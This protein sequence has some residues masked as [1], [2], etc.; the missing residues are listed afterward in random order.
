MLEL[1]ERHE[2]S[3][4]GVAAAGEQ[5]EPS[6]QPVE[7][8]VRVERLGPGRRE[9]EC[10]RHVVEPATQLLRLGSRLDPTACG[11]ERDRIVFRQRSDL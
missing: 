11:E 8:L 7:D 1:A 4:A 9:L 5:V 2:L 6:A 3:G 10:E